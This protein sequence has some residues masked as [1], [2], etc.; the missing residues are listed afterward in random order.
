MSPPRDSNSD[1]VIY[2]DTSTARLDL[3]QFPGSRPCLTL[4]PAIDLCC[5]PM[6][7]FRNASAWP[8]QVHSWLRTLPGLVIQQLASPSPH[9][10]SL[11]HAYHAATCISVLLKVPFHIMGGEQ[12]TV[13]EMGG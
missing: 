3:S 7:A 8:L 2:R 6:T 1:K 4:M 13:R 11:S 10:L 5:S 12:V 9:G